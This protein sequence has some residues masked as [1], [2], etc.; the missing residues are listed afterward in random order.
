MVQMSCVV[1]AQVS[2]TMGHLQSVCPD[3]E[4]ECPSASTHL[5]LPSMSINLTI[6]GFIS[7]FCEQR[8]HYFLIPCLYVIGYVRDKERQLCVE[9][10][11][12]TVKSI[13]AVKMST[14]SSS[15]CSSDYDA[16]ETFASSLVEQVD[17]ASVRNMVEVQRDM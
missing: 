3:T 17:N 14:S 8:I 16:A 11:N 4:W 9:I 2:C 6:A 13:K 5:I 10:D 12:D 7:T 15:D 1:G